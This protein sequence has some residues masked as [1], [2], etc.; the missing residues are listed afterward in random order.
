MLEKVLSVS[1]KPG[2]YLLV[3]RGRNNFIVETID[4]Q[5]K[6][7]PV[8]ST[9]RVISL[10]DIAMYTEDDDVKLK[11]VLK[12]ILDKEDNKVCGINPKTATSKEL[13]DYFTEVLPNW[14][15]DRVHDSDIKKLL[16]WYNILVNNNIDFSED[17][18][19]EEEEEKEEAEDK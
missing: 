13:H 11:F 3:S 1:G 12:N 6:R 9:D 2:L 7:C 4:S 19:E 17:L 8:F 18:M 5:K 10:A 16:Q 14:D 15:R